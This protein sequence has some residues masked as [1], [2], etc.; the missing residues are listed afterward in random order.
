MEIFLSSE[1]T[2]KDINREFKKS[3]PLLQLEFYKRKHSLSE[4]STWE[5][6]FPERTFLKDIN[7]RFR[8]GMIKINPHDTVAELEQRFQ[9]NFD[10]SVQV[11]RLM[12]EVYIETAQ[13]D[14]LSLQQQNSMGHVA[15]RPIFNAN[16]LFL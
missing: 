3:F 10:L 16:T 7:K 4:T 5:H 13:T 12:G 14:D 1:S 9:R 6:K 2:I 8:P 15:D 11:Y